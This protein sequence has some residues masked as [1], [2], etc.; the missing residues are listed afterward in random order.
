MIVGARGIGNPP[1][2]TTSL[3]TINTIPLNDT[4]TR[5]F[6]SIDEPDKDQPQDSSDPYLDVPMDSSMEGGEEGKGTEKEPESDYLKHQKPKMNAVVSPRS[7]NRV[8]K[9]SYEVIRNVNGTMNMNTN[10]RGSGERND[11]GGSLKGNSGV[12]G[13]RNPSTTS[14][15]VISPTQLQSQRMTMTTLAGMA[16]KA[17]NI[18]TSAANTIR[19]DDGEKEKEKDKEKDKGNN[20]NDVDSDEEFGASADTFHLASLKDENANE[21]EEEEEQ[22]RRMVRGNSAMFFTSRKSLTMSNSDANTD[23]SQRQR[24]ALPRGN[25]AKFS[26]PFSNQDV[27]GL[28]EDHDNSTGANSGDKKIIRR[29]SA[30]SMMHDNVSGMLS[31]LDSLRNNSDQSK[32]GLLPRSAAVLADETAHEVKDENLDSLILSPTLVAP[33]KHETMSSGR[34]N[35]I[36]AAVA[37]PTTMV[38]PPHSSPS[39]DPMMSPTAA[40]V[41]STAN[42]LTNSPQQFSQSQHQPPAGA[43]AAVMSPRSALVQLMNIRGSSRLNRVSNAS[44][45]KEM[46]S[47]DS[48]I[49]EA[50]TVSKDEGVA[51]TLQEAGKVDYLS[52]SLGRMSQNL[53][54]SFHPELVIDTNANA[55]ANPAA[56]PVT[57]FTAS[58]SA[59]STSST[60][61]INNSSGNV[62][63]YGI[64]HPRSPRSGPLEDRLNDSSKPPSNDK[65]QDKSQDKQQSVDGLPPIDTKV[66][67]KKLFKSSDA[68]SSKT[69]TGAEKSPDAVEDEQPGAPKK[70]FSGWLKK[71]FVK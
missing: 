39:V 50:T 3:A 67:H 36:K 40:G 16:G 34:L 52:R 69:A 9:T 57:A 20:A 58:G 53:K 19:R 1:S 17:R 21:E 60:S 28:A 31:P 29:Y 64:N 15:G 37:S 14:Y 4:D 42:N 18:A 30:I 25:S 12:I 71:Q 10:M 33:I 46:A 32:G 59:Q 26:R 11:S 41:S 38:H 47:K 55:N 68:K 70:K 6:E 63:F 5:H 45:E 23:E 62:V 48:K 61:N 22:H 13:E 27:S 44:K 49:E 7:P 56:T 2:V 24:K 35:S 43:S 65:S 54:K 66:G 8:V 51:P